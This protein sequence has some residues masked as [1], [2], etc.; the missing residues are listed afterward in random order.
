MFEVHFI[1]PYC[2]VQYLWAR[3]TVNT[4]K[5]ENLIQCAGGLNHLFRRII[6]SNLRYGKW[7]LK[8]CIS[9]LGTFLKYG[10]EEELV[11]FLRYWILMNLV[12]VLSIRVRERQGWDGGQEE[13][14]GGH[15]VHQ[16]SKKNVEKT[17]IDHELTSPPP[18]SHHRN[19]FYN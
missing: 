2:L 11:Q 6:F 19:E 3:H 12:Y 4:R 9:Y 13:R 5:D 10:I 18:S 8:N 7:F 16:G 14:A 17:I 15:P 1:K